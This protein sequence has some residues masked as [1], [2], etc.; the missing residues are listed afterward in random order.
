M[1]AIMLLG[2]LSLEGE[3][4]VLAG[5]AAQ[6]HRLALVALLAL[7]YPRS[8]SRDRLTSYLWPDRDAHHA[9][10]LLKQ[11]VHALRRAIGQLAILSAGDEL[12]L[13]TDAVACDM[14]AFDAA[15]ARGEVERAAALYGGPLLDGFHL[16][17]TSQFEH[18]IDCARDRLRQQFLKALEA[19]AEAAMREGDWAGAVQGWRRLAAEEPYNASVTF[20][21][22][23]ALDASGDRAGAILQARLHARLLHQHFAAAADDQVVA[24]AER[25]RTECGRGMPRATRPSVASPPARRQW[26]LRRARST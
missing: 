25:L 16:P 11:S 23:E 3:H 26:N 21:L 19:L 5:P 8:M 10:N 4:G 7:S 12:R 9:R 1:P 2:G 22:M 18:R 15:F 13:N 24:L 17:R 14:I 6:K 20:G